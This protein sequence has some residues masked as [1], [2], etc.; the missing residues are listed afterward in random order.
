MFFILIVN[1]IQQGQNVCSSTFILIYIVDYIFMFIYFYTIV[2]TLVLLNSKIQELL[3]HSCVYDLPHYLQTYSIK[4]DHDT[5]GLESP[6]LYQPYALQ[7]SF[8]IHFTL[9]VHVP[10]KPE[11]L[12]CEEIITLR[13]SFHTHHAMLDRVGTMSESLLHDT[14]N[15]LQLCMSL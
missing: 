15:A 5:T 1:M 13:L 2:R 3:I 12:Y 10:T 9:L 7:Q 11:S 4:L 6:F 14:R 8:H